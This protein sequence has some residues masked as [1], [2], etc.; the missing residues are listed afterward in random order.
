VLIQHIRG[1]IFYYCDVVAS[2]VITDAEK[3]HVS[4]LQRFGGR[5]PAEA[6]S[7][8]VVLKMGESAL[9]PFTFVLAWVVAHH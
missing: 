9:A 8:E 2:D 5:D 7:G 6:F 4:A 3:D 1:W